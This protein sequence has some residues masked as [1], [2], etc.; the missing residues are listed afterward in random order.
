M[1]EAGMDFCTLVTCTPYGINSHRLLVR[2]H[3][4][5]YVAEDLMGAGMNMPLVIIAAIAVVAG[6]VTTVIVLRTRKKK[7]TEA[8]TSTLEKNDT[9]S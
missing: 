3:R 8:V 5:E 9:K 6:I 4:V 1:P 2:G 7:N